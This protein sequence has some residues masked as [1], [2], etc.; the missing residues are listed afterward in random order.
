LINPKILIMNSQIITLKHLFLISTLCFL[1][2]L[3]NAQ[4]LLNDDYF[5][6][7]GEILV[8]EENGNSYL[9]IQPDIDGTGGYFA[10][11]NGLGF[12]GFEMDGNTTNDD[13]RI[14]IEGSGSS[15]T[16]QTW[17]SGDNAVSFPVDAINSTE[18]LNES[19]AVN[20]QTSFVNAG[21]TPTVA[22]SQTLNAPADGFALVIASCQLNL[23]HTNGLST[24]GEIGVSD[25]D[26]DL[27]G[28][29]DIGVG[30]PSNSPTGGFFQAASC[31]GI[32]TVT[33]GMNEFYFLLDNNGSGT[34]SAN[35]VSL[36]IIY[37]PT[38]YGTLTSN[39]TDN[40]DDAQNGEVRI[41]SNV[42]TTEKL[43]TKR[44][45][46][47][48]DNLARMEKELKEMQEFVDQIKQSKGNN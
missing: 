10:I 36:S 25:I 48:E 31:H 18:I 28:V 11:L 14:P 12:A 45:K 32:F 47:I 42:N 1:S 37:I 35:D 41:S 26:N 9:I 34:I 33:E 15:T 17:N 39:F 27:L 40:E 23:N 20:D 4:I 22:A 46:S 43:K 7:G 19:G 5:S 13:A 38:S 2:S 16:F 30:V 21:S 6:A 29:N 24:L 8:E 3:I 44:Q